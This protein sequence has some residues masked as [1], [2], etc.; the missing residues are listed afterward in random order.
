MIR[1]NDTD[2][3]VIAVATLSQLQK[4]GLPGM[5]I[6][7]GQRQNLKWISAQLVMIMILHHVHVPYFTLLRLL[8]HFRCRILQCITSC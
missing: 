7:F 4:L 1:T 6:A 3:L 5:W 2:V 8:A